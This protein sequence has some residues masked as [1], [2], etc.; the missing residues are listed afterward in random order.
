LRGF[1]QKLQMVGIADRQR[2]DRAFDPKLRAGP[3]S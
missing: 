3:L 1:K 2:S